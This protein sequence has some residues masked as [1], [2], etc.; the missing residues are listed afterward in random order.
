MSL[1]ECA[2]SM[3]KQT[4][5]LDYLWA[6]VVWTTIYL[7]NKTPMKVIVGKTLKEMWTS[8]KPYVIHLKMFSCQAYVHVP[9]QKKQKLDSKF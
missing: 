2:K 3:L 1:Q 8:E 6:E 5:L 4:K 7:Q 9:T